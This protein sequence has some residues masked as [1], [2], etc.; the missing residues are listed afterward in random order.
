MITEINTQQL[1][2]IIQKITDRIVAN[3]DTLNTLD[4]A[5][6]DGDHGTG[7]SIAFSAASEAI[8]GLDDADMM[9]IL[10]TTATTI[11]NRMGGASGALYG[12][13]FLKAAITAKDKNTLNK[14]DFDQLLQAGL[15]GVKQRGKS[16]IGDKTMVDALQPA[17]IA[18]TEAD[19]LADGWQHAA[20]S[21]HGGAENTKDMIAKHG[22]AKFAGER[23]R[24]YIDAGASSIALMFE[25]INQY[26][27][28]QH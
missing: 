13:F 22:R 3:R 9:T 8:S 28:E 2:A 5:L 16:D 11:M 1:M 7:I 27:E 15:D 14:S 4:S 17:V 10:K 19:T 21:A 24:G 20:A 18:F 6:G 26:W 12:T 23:S 25:A